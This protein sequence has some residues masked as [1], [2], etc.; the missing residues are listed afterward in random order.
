MHLCTHIASGPMGCSLE[1]ARPVLD[2][3]YGVEVLRQQVT[4]VREPFDSVGHPAPI[5]Q[6]VWKAVFQNQL[7]PCSV[8]LNIDHLQMVTT[9]MQITSGA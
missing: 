5:D 1:G 2:Y 4:C 8:E 6:W 3:F 9:V 7:G